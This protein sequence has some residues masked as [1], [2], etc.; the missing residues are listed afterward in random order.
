MTP[1]ASSVWAIVIGGLPRTRRA[2]SPRPMP[3]SIR[4][5]L[6]SSSVARLDA[7]TDGSRVPGFVTHVPSRSFDVCSAMSVSRGYGSR[8]RTCESN[9]QR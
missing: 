9:S 8:H 1:I 3:R 2:E 4:P 6:S 7:V 5:P